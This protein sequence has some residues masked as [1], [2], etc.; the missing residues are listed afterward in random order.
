LASS[1]VRD[2]STILLNVGNLSVQ[3]WE[4]FFSK[5]DVDAI[6][7]QSIPQKGLILETNVGVG[8]LDSKNMTPQKESDIDFE[9][10]KVCQIVSPHKLWVLIGLPDERSDNKIRQINEIRCVV[11]AALKLRKLLQNN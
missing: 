3:G 1:G 5:V 7:F 4:E 9:I 2:D 11:S 6:L 8:I 10:R